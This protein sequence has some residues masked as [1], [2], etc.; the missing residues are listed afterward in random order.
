[1]PAVYVVGTVDTKGEEL[2]YV[3]DLV[4]ATGLETVLVDVGTRST[5]T[6]ADVGPAELGEHHPDGVGALGSED[7]GEA[8]AA[9]A[10]ALERYVVAHADD[11]A[12][13]IGLGG[14]GGTA[15]V[16]PAMRALPVGV[17]KVMVSTVASGDVAPYVG[18]SD[19]TM[20]Y[21]VTDVAGLNRISRVI[22]G[23]AAHAVAGMVAHPVD[24]GEESVPP[25]GLTMFGVTTPLVEQLAEGLRD[26]WEPLVFHATGTGGQSLEKLVEG[27]MVGAVL[28]ST[29]TEVAD[30]VV[31][32]VMSAGP[33]RLDVLATRP[34]PWVG[35]VGACDMVNFAARATV[36]ETHADRL[37]H[38]H[39]A[40]VTLMRTT[41]EENRE[42]GAFIAAKL[43]AA[44]G[45]VRLLL[46][47][48]GVSMLDAE[49]QAFWDPEAD[50][51][52]FTTLE[53]QVEQTS[54]RQVRRVDAHVN[55]AEF[56]RALL[57]AFEEVAGSGDTRSGSGSGGSG[58]TG[59]GATG[60][61]VGG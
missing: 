12:G 27:G 44:T 15:L 59:S 45:P 60:D 40:N 11:V 6:G 13:I 23:N 26:R 46:P 48:R 56:A 18:P 1:M 33:G 50:E 31:G 32:G 16:T 55:D 49:G 38:V 47:T 39:N 29:T 10:V 3:R 35:S 24:P 57:D 20:T 51:A 42:I 4:A 28:D 5:G 19:V 54:D 14:S 30:H 9:M 37:L 22:L 7:R 25:V 41:P 8:V 36:P 21:S 43:N 34:V 58:A 2:R 17:P 52:L 53:E 61:V